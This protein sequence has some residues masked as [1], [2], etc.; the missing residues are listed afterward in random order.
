M[1]Q[2]YAL[3]LALLLTLMI[4]ANISLVSFSGSA[5]EKLLIK[6]VID[7]DTFTSG[8]G[9]KVR[10][11]NINTPEKSEKGYEE[12]KEFLSEFE[13][14]T[15]EVE[16]LGTD[17]YGRSLARVFTPDYINLELVK[18]GLATKFL[19]EESELQLFA[20]AEESAIQNALG[21]WEKSNYFGCF[22]PE[23][24]PKKELV[25]I[26][27]ACPSISVTGWLVKDESRKRYKFP[28]ILLGKINLHTEKGEDN[29]TDLF[30]QSSQN[31]WNDDRDTFYLLDSE[32]KLVAY[33]NYGY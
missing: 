24:S 10:L 33:E 30:W 14:S 27:N 5:R 3:I 20:Q 23:L 1:K 13:N 15:V 8:D 16:W 7:G 11:V 6:K 17:K 31:I 4:A 28:N 12:A 22:R 32:G 2:K 19:V 26:E 21:L 25:Q 18:Q 9:T 29:E